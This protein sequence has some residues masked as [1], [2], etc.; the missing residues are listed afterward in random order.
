MIRSKLGL[1]VEQK[2]VHR[3][4]FSLYSRT[5]RRL[6]RLHCMWVPYAKRKVPVR[7][8]NLSGVSD[9]QFL[10]SRRCLF[11][12]RTFEVSVLH[13]YNW[14]ALRADHVIGIGDGRYEI[15]FAVPGGSLLG[16]LLFSECAAELSK[17]AHN[18]LLAFCAR[19]H[20]RPFHSLIGRYLR[21]I[22]S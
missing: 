7:E 2:V 20:F 19:R 11:A 14:R 1:V 15:K 5:L 6:R 4:E 22:D 3:P 16:S 8:L 18:P 9:E 21:P 13:N 12:G 10:E 17:R